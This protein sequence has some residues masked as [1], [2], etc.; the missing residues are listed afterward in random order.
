MVP[1]IADKQLA[2]EASVSKV[3]VSR[4]QLKLTLDDFSLNEKNRALNCSPLLALTNSRDK[5]I[6][7]TLMDAG[8]ATER[9][10]IDKAVAVK[11]DSKT[12]LIA[13]K[14]TTDVKASAKQ[15]ETKTVAE[16]TTVP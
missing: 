11:G 2:S 14:L 12:K 5:A 1:W 6:Q 15:A 7:K 3:K 13:T 4:F 16:P 10:H 8:T 9:V